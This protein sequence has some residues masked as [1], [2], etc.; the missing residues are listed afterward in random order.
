MMKRQN[1]KF[2]K[3]AA[4]LMC[5]AFLFACSND[6]ENVTTNNE[7]IANAESLSTIGNQ[8]IASVISEH[9]SYSDEDFYDDWENATSI[10][11]NGSDAS[12]EGDDGVSIDNSIITINTSGVY[13]I[14]G[15]LDDGQ[16]IV[17]TEDDGIVRLVLN[18]AEI[19]SSSTSA[20]YVKQAEKAIVS[21]EEGT[22]N[23]LSDG[24][25]YVYENSEE[26]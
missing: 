23:V 13:E 5:T 18:G 1:S 16:I 19:H 4:S 24:A 17:D 22:E 12:F 3:V 2:M 20:I 15:K 14:Q 26:D 11:L 6:S 25:K 8:E 9:V 21:L 10:Q 7:S